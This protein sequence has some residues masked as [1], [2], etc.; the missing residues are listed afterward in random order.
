MAQWTAASSVVDI[1]A[2]FVVVCGTPL[3]L[4]KK[5]RAFRFRVTLALGIFAVASF[6]LLY[7]LP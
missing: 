5:S 2:C 1:V 4:R 6:A 7:F 3:L